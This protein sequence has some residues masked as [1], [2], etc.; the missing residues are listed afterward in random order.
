MSLSQEEQT[1]REKFSEWAEKKALGYDAEV[2]RLEA[3]I[4]KLGPYHRE[5][6]KL[7]LERTIARKSALA[8]AMWLASLDKLTYEDTLT[9]PIPFH[10]RKDLYRVQALG[11]E[12]AARR[13]DEMRNIYRPWVEWRLAAIGEKII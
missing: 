6:Q 10:D 3:I 12:L 1:Y 4:P 13:S 2:E 7:D 9:N 5:E 8:R 11:Y